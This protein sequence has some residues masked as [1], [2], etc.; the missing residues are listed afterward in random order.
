MHLE[1][2]HK[3]LK[4]KYQGGKKNKR[5]DAAVASV[6][7]MVFDKK[8]DQLISLVRPKYTKKLATLRNRHECSLAMNVLCTE[9]VEFQEWAVQSEGDALEIYTVKKVQQVCPVS[10]GIR[11]DKCN[12][13]THMFRCTCP[14][15]AIKDNMCKHIL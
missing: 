5:L 10:C 7:T 14:D 9:V 6:M 13:C 12:A 3:T 8:Y 1:R 15:M 2:M 4:Y 11:C